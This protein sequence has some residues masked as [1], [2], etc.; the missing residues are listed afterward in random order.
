MVRRREIERRNVR[1]MAAGTA[2]S[3][4]KPL[5][6]YRLRI[7]FDDGREAVLPMKQKL[8]G[9]VFEPLKDKSFFRKV[10]VDC[11]DIIWPNQLDL[12]PDVMYWDAL[13]ATPLQEP[14]SSLCK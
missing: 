9:Q 12:C 3:L 13:V 1:E 5:S 6:V 4:L 7:R 11:G 10:Y 2:L 14:E 8:W